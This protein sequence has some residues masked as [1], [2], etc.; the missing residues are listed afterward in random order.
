MTLEIF[1]EN[2][3]M[4]PSHGFRSVDG[5]RNG[6]RGIVDKKELKTLFQKGKD[7]Q[8]RSLAAKIAK[9]LIGH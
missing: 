4:G 1:G 7:D 6:I 9:T 8:D 5:D 2:R 3:L